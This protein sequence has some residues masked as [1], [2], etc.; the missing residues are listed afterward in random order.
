MP[1]GR[2]LFRGASDHALLQ[3]SLV[4][5]V[6]GL[7]LTVRSRGVGHSF[8]SGDLFRHMTVEA[9][10]D[11]AWVDVATF[12]RSF[13]VDG[14]VKSLDRDTSL[15]PD[16]P[17]SVSLPPSSSAW[18]IRYHYALAR[19]EARGVATPVVVAEGVLS[20]ADRSR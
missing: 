17:Q 12:G 4:V 13:R 2:H 15:Q 19:T 8:P 7:V 5:D 18:R 1:G 14:L 20:G 6:A 16:V 11:G 3:R 9:L 10:D